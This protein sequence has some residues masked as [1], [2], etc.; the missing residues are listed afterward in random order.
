MFHGMFRESG[1][2]GHAVFRHMYRLLSEN[3]LK[4]NEQTPFEGRGARLW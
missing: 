2:C 3:H 4:Y 1:S